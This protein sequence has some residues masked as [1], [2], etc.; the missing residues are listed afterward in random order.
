[1][2]RVKVIAE[3]KRVIGVEPAMVE[4]PS[5]GGFAKLDH[6]ILL[7]DVKAVAAVGVTIAH[8][9][10]RIVIDRCR[11]PSEAPPVILGCWIIDL[12]SPFGRKLKEPAAGQ[13]SGADKQSI[14]YNDFENPTRLEPFR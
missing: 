4:M 9:F 3:G 1:V 12:D 11:I 8:Q 13:P 14:S 6:G 5:L 7:F 10:T 2:S